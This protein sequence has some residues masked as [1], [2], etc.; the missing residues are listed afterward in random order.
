[1]NGCGHGCAG[2]FNHVRLRQRR[3]DSYRSD[4]AFKA[5][6][7][8]SEY[9]LCQRPLHIVKCISMDNIQHILIFHLKS[10]FSI[11]YLLNN[12]DK[13]FVDSI[14]YEAIRYLKLVP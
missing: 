14:I 6:I 7:F 3:R 11:V 2:K 10:I 1:M 12:M 4:V 8:I 13:T 5:L 9:W